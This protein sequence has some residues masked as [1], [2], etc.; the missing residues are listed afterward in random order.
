MSDIAK[1]LS[2][3]EARASAATPGPWEQT[4]Y[5]IWSPNAKAVIAGA[6]AL[7]ATNEVRYAEP[8]RD[9][10]LHEI[11]GNAAFIAA[12]RDAVPRLV[13]ALRHAMETMDAL[14]RTRS[15]GELVENYTK[16][17]KEELADILYGGIDNKTL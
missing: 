17:R 11:F 9:E 16:H 2:E 6:S 8:H 10:D 1:L 12:S 3:I 5:T 13:A 7:R 4:C 15:A 14:N